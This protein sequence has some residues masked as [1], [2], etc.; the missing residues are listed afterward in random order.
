MMVSFVCVDKRVRS[1]PD[2]A[3]IAYE[4]AFSDC[5]PAAATETSSDFGRHRFMDS[6]KATTA[7]R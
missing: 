4:I 6:F 3:C 7:T 2:A 1:S 5:T